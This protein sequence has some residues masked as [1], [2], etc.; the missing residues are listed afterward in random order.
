MLYTVDARGPGEDRD[1]RLL[2]RIESEPQPKR[3]LM[4]RKQEQALQATEAKARL[5]EGLPTSAPD[6]A[7]KVSSRRAL[8]IISAIIGF[9][10]LVLTFAWIPAWGISP[11]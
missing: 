7:K 6:L 11:W 5:E 9:V 4:L 10:G 3:D 2:I 8:K 1:P